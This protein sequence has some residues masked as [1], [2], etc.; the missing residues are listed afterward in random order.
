MSGTSAGL[1]IDCPQTIASEC[2]KIPG[3]RYVTYDN[4]ASTPC[5]VSSID[6]TPAGIC[7]RPNIKVTSWVINGI[8]VVA[9]PFNDGWDECGTPFLSDLAASLNTWDPFA[10]GWTVAVSDTCAYHVRSRAL[11][12]TGTDYGVLTAVDNDTGDVL[13]FAPAETVVQD[14]VFRRIVEVDC[15]GQTSVRWTN[16]AGATVP[17]PNPAQIVECSV[18]VTPGARVTPTMRIRPRIQRYTGTESSPNFDSLGSDV[19]AVTLTVLAGA[20]RVRAAGS[21]S[22]NG[23]APT[24]Y[25]DDVAVPAGV[26]LTWGVDGDSYD[27]A[28]DGSLIF[29]GTAAGADFI[30]HWTEHLY[31]DQD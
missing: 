18:Q 6:G 7:D 12:P 28:L 14:Q 16:A 22:S 20:V 29:T 1:S 31:T 3:Y 25:A 10:G 21:G 24:A 15:Q 27:L 5:G 9:A 17:A 26:T 30:V 2:W 4:S 13:T 19:Q 8:N 11:P 23:G